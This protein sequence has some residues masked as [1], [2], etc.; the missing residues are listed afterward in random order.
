[1]F[2]VSVTAGFAAA[3]TLRFYKGKCERLHGHNWKVEVTLQG[4]ELDKIGV[5]YDFTELK[6]VLNGVIEELDHRN[7]NDV[8]GFK[9][10]NPTSENIARYIYMRMKHDLAGTSAK[11]LKVKVWESDTSAAAYRP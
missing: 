3:H 10:I 8:T 9:N 7:L 2:E 5:V 4:G 6:K 11:L 1:M